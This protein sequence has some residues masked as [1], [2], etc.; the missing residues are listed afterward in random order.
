MSAYGTALPPAQ[1]PVLRRRTPTGKV[2]Y[3]LVILEG[4]T[5]AGKSYEAAKFTGDQRLGESFWI[6]LGGGDEGIGEEYRAVPD[7]RHTVLEHDGTFFSWYGQ[8]LAAKAEARRVYDAGDPPVVLIIDSFTAVWEQIKS[9]TYARAAAGI[10]KAAKGQPVDPN[11]EV[12]PGRN[13]WNDA[14]DRYRAVMTQLLSFPGIVVLTAKGDW[15]S[16]TDEAS[17]KPTTEREYRV[18]AHKS[19]VSDATVCIRLARGKKPLVWKCRSI[20]AGID[21]SEEPKELENGLDLGWLIF[22]VMKCD[23]RGALVVDV[24]EGA[25]DEL[26]AE[27]TEQ[28]KNG[29]Q[30][31]WEAAREKLLADRDHAGLQGLW[32][33]AKVSGADAG[34]LHRIARD[35]KEL[36]DR[37]AN[38]A[39]HASAVAKDTE[40]CKGTAKSI[41]AAGG[42][43]ITNKA[44]GREIG[45]CDQC[46]QWVHM[47]SGKALPHGVQAQ[48]GGR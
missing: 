39:E 11:R 19:L 10:A 2:R 46:Q 22:D 31:D 44:T 32:T 28:P 7:A 20:H 13:L 24:K 42:M 6:E 3:P 48:G 30:V 45:F 12:N 25:V 8:V 41:D 37:F 27:D 23:P 9:W 14:R 43:V 16:G 4:Q 17:G 1:K 34:T 18:D 5:S 15:V 40:L 36:A 47:Q 38:E 26:P 21:T 35:G 33:A 29:Q